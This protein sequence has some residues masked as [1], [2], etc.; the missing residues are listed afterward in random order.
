VFAIREKETRTGIKL[1]ITM[2]LAGILLWI[3]GFGHVVFER[4]FGVA[5]APKSIS[6]RVHVLQAIMDNWKKLPL[7]GVGPGRC[8]EFAR[9]IG[10][11]SGNL[12]NEFILALLSIGVIGPLTMLL[13]GVRRFLAA[14]HTTLTASRAPYM[15][16][17]AA[18]FINLGTYNL[19]SWSN[20]PTLTFLCC[21]LVGRS[22]IQ[23]DE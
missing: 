8:S 1:V 5:S 16:I 7:L 23:Y 6:L 2:L 22:G 12:E 4:L 3:S 21:Y 18:L 10:L 11:R 14:R 13:V 19:F 17:V 20:G 9:Q 15:A